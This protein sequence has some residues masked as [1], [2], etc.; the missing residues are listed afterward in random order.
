MAVT[1]LSSAVSEQFYSGIVQITD[2]ATATG[3]HLGAGVVLTASHVVFDYGE[4]ISLDALPQDFE[5]VSGAGTARAVPILHDF[6]AND[7]LDLGSWAQTHSYSDVSL[8]FTGN[9]LEMPRNSILIFEDEHTIAGDIEFFGYPSGSEGYGDSET[10]FHS[11]GV[12]HA[13]APTTIVSNRSGFT[14]A[15]LA[16]E[17]GTHSMAGFS[18]SGVFLTASHMTFG[19]LT[20]LIGVLS[21]STNNASPDAD[22]SYIAPLSSVYADL[23]TAVHAW[24]YSADAFATNTLVASTNGQLNGTFFNEIL[25]GSDGA[26]RLSGGAGDDQIFAESGQ[27]TLRGGDGDDTLHVGTTPGDTLGLADGG[28]GIDTVIFS[29]DFGTFVERSWYNQAD[30]SWL[31]RS[32]M[33]DEESSYVITNVEVFQFDD[34]TFDLRNVSDVKRLREDFGYAGDLMFDISMSNA[35]LQQSQ[36]TSAELLLVEY[37]LTN[38]GGQAATGVRQ[39][40]WLSADMVFG[41]ADDVL[42]GGVQT[43]FDIGETRIEQQELGIAPGLASGVYYVFVGL[44]RPDGALDTDVG[45]SNPLMLE[46]F[47]APQTSTLLNDTISGNDDANL[48]NGLAGD[49]VILGAGGNDT[50]FGD[51]GRDEVTGGAGSDTIHGG[52]DDD[53]LRGGLDDDGIRG[54]GG[55]DVLAGNAGEDVLRGNEGNDRIFGGAEDDILAGN[56]GDDWLS[57]G[58]GSDAIFGGSGRDSVLGSRGDDTLAGGANHDKMWGGSGLD[59]LTGN[60]GADTVRGGAGGDVID[61][62]VDD[63]VLAGNSGNDSVFGG[64]GHDTLFG[65]SG[66]DVLSGGSGSDVFVFSYVT[67]SMHGT[68]PD[69]I[70]DFQTGEDRINLSRLG[71]SLVFVENYSGSAGE[72]RYNE[73]LGHLDV[74]LDGDRISDVSVELVGVP[75]LD[76]DDLIL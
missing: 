24:G 1:A 76:A 6:S 46:V 67:D 18:G 51:L 4:G 64:A 55:R 30:N 9:A 16:T 29:S 10:M 37:R 56:A 60:E 53:M 2:T 73:N 34:L 33:G 22:V 43:D 38:Q 35:S 7:F 19:P 58:L 40:V 15:V 13:Q 32:S 21:A 8:I 57:G 59:Y 5:L 47:S 48:I 12:I 68:S 26:D 23:A 28:N 25:L 49:D 3:I 66:Q 69:R 75:S 61:G 39:E 20:G 42:L 31:I 45:L 70:L 17:P 36:M 72:V 14:N 65:G 63:D 41:N 27:D 54:G 52:N 11:E 50:L 74:D 62:G 44:P 71:P